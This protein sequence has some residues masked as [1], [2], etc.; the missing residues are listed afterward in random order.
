MKKVISAFS[1]CLILSIAPGAEIKNDEALTFFSTYAFS[2]GKGTIALAVHGWI[3]EPKEDSIKRKYLIDLLADAAGIEKD[4]AGYALFSERIKY[5]LVDNHGD[6][7]IRL[8]IGKQII[9]M[10]ESDDNGHFEKEIVMNKSEALTLFKR[11]VLHYSAVTA[12]GDSRIFTGEIHYI[13]P[14]GISVIS[15][16]D[17][18]IKISNVL[19]KKELTRNTF[20]KE[21]SAVPGMADQYRRWAKK[22][23]SFH[24]VSGS[25]WQLYIPFSKFFS[26]EKFPRGTVHL[27][28]FRL[29]DSSSLDFITADQLDYKVN[30]ISAIM[31]DFPQRQFILVGDSGENDPEVYA[32]IA[33]KYGKRIKAICI[34][35]VKNPNDKK[36]RFTGL[37]G[38]L[39]DIRFVLFD[40]SEDIDS[41]L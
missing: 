18:T 17:D 22:G 21:F 28:Y 7:K 30:S 32:E 2:A 4:E 12:P 3:Y 10:P 41:L 16:I 20:I 11:N 27:K 25:P 29:K 13:P 15:D 5:F 23:F 26:R 31:D 35:D 14:K 6:K 19:Q 37:F 33:K 36:D 39:R 8:K 1:L 38:H 40:N 24:Y 34:R 9:D